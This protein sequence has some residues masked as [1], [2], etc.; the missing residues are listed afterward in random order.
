MQKKR[1]VIPLIS[2]GFIA[3]FLAIATMGALAYYHL[4]RMR[5]MV[6]EVPASDQYL[7]Y[8]ENL[9]GRMSQASVS[10]RTFVMTTVRK[11][12]RGYAAVNQMIG[13]LTLEDMLGRYQG[14][15]DTVPKL[16]EKIL[17]LVKERRMLLNQIIR[18]ASQA[19]GA[20]K[21]E[22]GP[23]WIP[24]D[25]SRL[26]GGSDTYDLDPLETIQKYNEQIAAEFQTY[27]DSL[28]IL[29]KQDQRKADELILYVDILDGV[30]NDEKKVKEKE[31][32]N[33]ARQATIF[34]ASSA[35]L[36]L[37]VFGFFLAKILRDLERNHQLELQLHEEKARAEKLA[38]AKEEFLANMSHEMRTPMNAVIGFADRLHQTE[39]STHQKY[40]LQPIRHSAD[41]LLSLI[42]DVLDYSKLESGNFTLESS[43][44]NPKAIAEEVCEL[45]KLKA[46]EQG[47]AL[48]T[49][50]DEDLPEAIV[51]DPLR[52]KQMLLNLV[53]NALKFTAEGEVAIRVARGPV[54]HTK[55]WIIFEVKDTGIG[56]AKEQQE[57]I[58]QDF[59]QADTSTSRK[60]GGTGL[61]LSITKKLTAMHGGNIQL[62]SEPGV[63]TT[64]QLVLP[65]EVADTV[66]KEDEEEKPFIPHPG[67]IG[68]RALLADDDAYNRELVSF[69]LSEL[70]IEV[71]QAAN[72]QEVVEIL[73]KDT[74]FDVIL[75]DLQM[76]E[77]DGI[78]ATIYVRKT[79]AL[80]LPIVA[81][82][83]TTSQREITHAYS[84]GMDSYLLKPF[85]P[86]ALQ[87]TLITL[88][89]IS[90]SSVSMNNPSFKL[91]KSM[92][93]GNK[94]MM[95]KMLQQYLDLVDPNY[96]ELE[97]ASKA[98]DWQK[99]A[100]VAHRM[101]P[102]QRHLE[103]TEIVK[104]LKSVQQDAESNVN[105]G[106]ISQRVLLLRDQLDTAKVQVAKE[107]QQMS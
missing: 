14:T 65:Y 80:D 15:E 38:K 104:N 60:Y 102:A 66:E 63:G 91:L 2:L 96:Q 26:P 31:V 97:Q 99:V 75:M 94:G 72:G 61:G 64:I 86:E 88:L 27:K 9:T 34:I 41:L 68:K 30:L 101:L 46:Q 71:V 33:S 58:F 24:S 23:G 20:E 105:T 10:A 100:K 28:E 11:D 50:L 98:R 5:S 70:Q 95:K 103:F 32:R 17:S 106:E 81:L 12:L 56:I 82:T 53:S 57:L 3:A 62:D 6:V 16:S 36:I 8:V 49:Y 69:I 48:N 89:E 29:A 35:V 22:R 83:A 7:A 78:S 93:Q 84:V 79:L 59:I 43:P 74:R 85:R 90:D 87:D 25:S 73:Q 37:S 4:T 55:H 76:P 39:L 18:I 67:L 52:L 40:L 47:I 51:G 54:E 42:N 92:T 45:F 13:D 77:R 44:F 19:P 107:I 21:I 1:S